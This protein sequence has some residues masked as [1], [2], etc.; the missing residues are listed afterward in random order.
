MF[1]IDLIGVIPFNTIVDI[2]MDSNGHQRGLAL[3]RLARLVR[4]HRLWALFRDFE[5]NTHF[6]LIATTLIRNLTIVFLVGHCAA[7]LFYYIAREYGFDEDTWIGAN[8][9]LLS[10]SDGEKE[11]IS[12]DNW[13]KYVY[14]IYWSI[15]TMT[16]V[17]YGDYSPKNIAEVIFA[18]IYM[19]I[20]IALNSYILGKILKSFREAEE[21]FRDY[22]TCGNSS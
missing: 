18:T 4:A 7:C 19:L 10:E 12:Q 21:W 15:T 17:G 3:L 11:D 6:H 1:W 8:L 5:I 14:S 2:T 22:Y 16:T 20:N 13:K 9:D